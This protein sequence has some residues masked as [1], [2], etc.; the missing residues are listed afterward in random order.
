[1]AYCLSE[2]ETAQAYARRPLALARV[3][4]KQIGVMLTGMMYSNGTVPGHVRPERFSPLFGQKHP[5]VRFLEQTEGAV[6]THF[7]LVPW[8]PDVAARAALYAGFA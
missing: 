4:S 3:D 2:T 8:M 5:L 6:G 1:M 7:L